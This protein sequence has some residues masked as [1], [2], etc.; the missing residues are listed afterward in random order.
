[1]YDT[2]HEPFRRVSSRPA[3]VASETPTKENN[4]DKNVEPPSAE[5]E[6]R[7]EP[8]LN[9]K[10]A[11]TAAFAKYAER[12]RKPDEKSSSPEKGEGSSSVTMAP[13]V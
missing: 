1:M 11:L 3:V 8:T 9:V 4:K 2:F 12:V 5:S 13:K 6:A 10:S 7:K